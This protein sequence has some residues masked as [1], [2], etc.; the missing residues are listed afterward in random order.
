VIAGGRDEPLVGAAWR[1]L[2]EHPRLST[3]LVVAALAAVGPATVRAIHGPGLPGVVVLRSVPAIP[4]Q[5]AWQ[6]ADDGRPAGTSVVVTVSVAVQVVDPADAD[7]T[8]IGIAGPG[9]VRADNSAARLSTHD[10]VTVILLRPVVDCSRL[11]TTIRPGVYGLRVLAGPRSPARSGVVAAGRS[12]EQ[13]AATIGLAC[14]SWSARRD[15][16]VTAVTARVHPTL[17]QVDLDL[18]VTNTGPSQASLSVAAPSYPYLE[19]SG[20]LPLRVPAHGAATAAIRVTLE[21]CDPALGR[22]SG[23]VPW[24][25]PTMSTLIDLVALAGPVSDAPTPSPT[26]APDASTYGAGEGRGPTG[27]VLTAEAATA[28][29]GALSAAC[30]GLGPLVPIIEPGTVRYD[31][32]AGLLTVPLLLDVTPGRVRA[33]TL[34]TDPSTPDAGG[35]RPLWTETGELIPDRTGQ[36]RTVLRYGVPASAP[37]FEQGGYLPGFVATLRVPD[38]AGER[39]LRFSGFVDVGQD[40]GAVSTLCRGG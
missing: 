28:L 36:V 32:A 37:C 3:L 17:P 7:T 29:S 13:W 5:D 12:G 39:S 8:V 40:P 26:D 1:R 15:L 38:A 30:G 18:T 10:D 6:A 25:S 2:R 33:L 27:V 4:A 34:R 20:G 22:L 24:I 11:P 9:V 23:A 14:S 19:V 35:Y 21:R 16:T 31:P